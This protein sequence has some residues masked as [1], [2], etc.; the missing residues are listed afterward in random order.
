MIRALQRKFIVTAM[1]A[2]SVLLLVLLG[3][4]NVVNAWSSGQQ[5]D[6]M[7]AMLLENEISSGPQKPPGMRGGRGFLNPP[8]TEDTAMSAVYFW[9]LISD[10]GT[11]IQTDMSRIATV[12]EEEAKEFALQAYEQ[13]K[14]YGKI[15]HF[16]YGAAAAPNGKDQIFVFLDTS[17]QAYSVFRV[18]VLSGLAGIVCWCLMLLL[19]IL[20]SQK[21]IRPIA[22]NMERQKQ[23]ITDAG[24]EIKTPLAI[25]LANT[26]AME[27]H[28]GANKW[29]KNIRSQTVRLNGLM[30]NLLTVAKLDESRLSLHKEEFSLSQ[31]LEDSL[32]S[33]EESAELK[34]IRI[35]KEIQPDV[36]IY[37]ERN[38][39]AQ[40][41]SILLDNA[42]KYSPV[43]GKIRVSLQTK[44]RSVLLQ[45]GNT[46]EKQS[47]MD[48]MKLFDRF[49]R[50]DRAR[51]QKG[52]GYGI[53]LSAAKAI[54]ELHK[55]S[56]TAEYE[57]PDR[58]LFTVKL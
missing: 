16:K 27:L 26:D 34:N 38:Y 51:T 24:H 35:Q 45:M 3:T 57:E 15:S 18:L 48:P 36:T 56:I 19:V 52:G 46:C 44:Q 47:E 40:L 17:A 29:S 54:V 39:M 58:I 8:V 31:M 43:N 25:I 12:A 4:I 42:V 1:T 14:D 21:A 49:Y 33:F 50:G 53:G 7:L 6:R 28:N 22:A 30:Q 20:L 32:I 2:I 23:F 11:I 9:V 55:G 5:S 41:I 37:A 10:S 13:S